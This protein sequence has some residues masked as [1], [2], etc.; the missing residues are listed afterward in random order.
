MNN[1]KNRC[2]H[3]IVYGPVPS[4]RL[5]R[6][7]GVDM[8]CPPKVCTYDCVYCQI[9]PTPEKTINRKVFQKA[10]DV[11]KAVEH[12]VEMHQVDY[13]TLGGSGE[14]TLNTE[15]GKVIRAIKKR[16]NIPVAVLTNGSLLYDPEVAQSLMDADVIIPSLDAYDEVTFLRINR[17]H[18]S[19]TFHDMLSGLKS[20][21]RS[22]HGKLWLEIFLIPG[23]NTSSDSAAS[24][25]DIV[26]MID[27]DE[28][29]LNT[30]VRPAAESWVKPAGIP[31]MERIAKA[32]GA[33]A[34]II[35][36]RKNVRRRDESSK[37]DI[38]EAVA[39]M[40]ARRPC[41][42]ED[43]IN[44]LSLHRGQLDELLEEWVEWGKARVSKQG[45]KTYYFIAQKI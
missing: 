10:D 9:G 34:R 41:T 13:I 24:F 26:D 14:P 19:I 6:S 4:R 35:A 39:A 17:P 23:L 28:V 40:L 21:S 37:E 2:S 29:H 8:I 27:A 33:K 5:G 1:P 42:K 3:K 20:F 12:A 7:L 38:I 22:Y 16:M 25:A 44:A 32:I 31:E 36:A 30:A 43:L 11:V 18:S 15:T 45:G